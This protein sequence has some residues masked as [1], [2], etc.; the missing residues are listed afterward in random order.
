L[1]Q[2]NHELTKGINSQ[3]ALVQQVF[4]VTFNNPTYGIAGS[5]ALALLQS[6]VSANLQLDKGSKRKICNNRP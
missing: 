5:T 4:S 1:T 6:L 2:Q 3:L